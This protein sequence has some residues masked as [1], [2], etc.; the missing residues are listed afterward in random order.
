MSNCGCGSTYVS[1]I[2]VVSICDPCNTNTGC[3]IQLDWDCIIYHKDNNE[4]SNL[5]CLGLTNG[6]T[7]NQFAELIDTYICQLDVSEYSLPC[8]RE[9]YTINSLELFA[10]AVDTEICLIKD[11]IET[12]ETQINL[13]ITPIDSQSV[14]LTVSGVSNHTIQADLILDPA[15]DNRL[16]IS[17]TGVLVAP[18][19]L[20]PDYVN[21]TLK[22]SGANNV[23]QMASFFTTVQGYLGPVA[24]DPV[25]TV[26]GQ[27][28]YNTTSSLFKF[29]VDGTTIINLN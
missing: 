17:G 12:L 7:L 25:G 9:D 18:Q 22:I 15:T 23:V 19:V 13:P 24:S 10:E 21:K 26:A 4:V 6:A 16:S 27:S 1:P 20:Q 8:L 2:P 11:S 29:N 14:N 5:T 3:P 28:W